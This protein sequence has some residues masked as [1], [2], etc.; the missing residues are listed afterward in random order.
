MIAKRLDEAG[1]VAAAL[2]RNGLVVDIGVR[3][4]P[5]VALRADLDALPVEDRTDDPWTSTVP[6]VAHACGHDVHAS[7]LLGAGLALAARRRPSFPAACGW[8]SSRPR[9]SCPAAR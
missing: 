5:L 3:R 8:S 2:P 7:A 1:L 6:G 9:R 4:R